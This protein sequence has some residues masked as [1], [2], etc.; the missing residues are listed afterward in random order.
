MSRYRVQLRVNEWHFVSDGM[1]CK[2]FLSKN[3]NMM[4]KK[5]FFLKP[6][7]YPSAEHHPIN[8]PESLKPNT[9]HFPAL[10]ATFLCRWAE[11]YKEL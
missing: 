6:E 2:E 5:K 3:T 8:F 10:S 11:R 7:C 9:F 4:E 1:Y